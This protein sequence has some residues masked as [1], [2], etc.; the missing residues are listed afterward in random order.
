MVLSIQGLR[1]F[2]KGLSYHGLACKR[3]SAR[4]GLVV[5]KANA[6][7]SGLAATSAGEDLV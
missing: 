7:W 4:G 1:V 2:R 3:G 5:D 6:R